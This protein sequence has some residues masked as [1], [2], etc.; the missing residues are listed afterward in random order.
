MPSAWQLAG[1]LAL[2]ATGEA[3]KL[4]H[5][6]LLQGSSFSKEELQELLGTSEGGT[7]QALLEQLLTSELSGA[8]LE[9]ARSAYSPHATSQDPDEES[10]DMDAVLEELMLDPENVD[11]AKKQREVRKKRAQK[12][13][14]LQKEKH[15]IALA[16]KKE[17]AAATKAANKLKQQQSREKTAAKASLKSKRKLPFLQKHMRRVKM[18]AAESHQPDQPEPHGASG[19]YFFVCCI[20]LGGLRV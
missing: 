1:N 5:F 9:K 17:K 4:L 6:A 18:K 8:N 2:K 14:E 10:P 7:K 15:L 20:Y 3:D 13:T 16:Q 11:E 12:V 19:I